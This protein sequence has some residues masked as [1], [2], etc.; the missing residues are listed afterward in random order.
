MISG[1]VALSIRVDALGES[2]QGGILGLK[3]RI[4]VEQRLKQLESFL[5]KKN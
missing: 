4:K 5:K 3:N 1:K 2:K